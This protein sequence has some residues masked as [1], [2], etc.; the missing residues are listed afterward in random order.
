MRASVPFVALGLL[1]TSA[2][3]LATPSLPRAGDPSQYDDPNNGTPVAQ[4][5]GDSSLPAAAL[6]TAAKAGS[7]KLNSY[8]L[9]GGGTKKV[10]IY[11]DWADLSGVSI[12]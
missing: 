1:L 12:F 9:G 8:E 5:T 11:G 4:F 3:T 2:L 6:A 7:N 10:G